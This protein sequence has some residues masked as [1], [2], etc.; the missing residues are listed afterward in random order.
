MNV[1]E[2]APGED[3]FEYASFSADI[4]LTELGGFCRFI[5]VV[6][7]TNGTLV[8]RTQLS[9]AT[10]RTLTGLAAG[11]VIGPVQIRGIL[12]SGTANVTRIRCY[13]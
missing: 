8:V 12:A 3:L 13:R 10:G 6:S 5:Q 2:I 7:A 11:D 9:G 4:P 1:N